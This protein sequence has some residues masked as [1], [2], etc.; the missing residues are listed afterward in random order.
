MAT[1][2]EP[3]GVLSPNFALIH[4]RASTDFRMDLDPTKRSPGLLR[5]GV[6]LLT[7]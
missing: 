6:L 2:D 3:L 1:F 7:R 4:E 5:E